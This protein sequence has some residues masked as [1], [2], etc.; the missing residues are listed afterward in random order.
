MIIVGSGDLGSGV[1]SG[2]A[3]GGGAHGHLEVWSGSM[4]TASDVPRRLANAW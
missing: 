3:G 4:E 2:S 1:S